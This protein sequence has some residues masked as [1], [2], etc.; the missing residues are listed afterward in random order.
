MPQYFLNQNQQQNGD[1]EVHQERCT[2]MP[3]YPEALG[4][5]ASCHGAVEEA[6][7]RHPSWY[8]IN[9]CAFCSGACHTS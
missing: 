4:Y 9:G 8:R 6:K 1:Y 7:R 2:Y 3:S 5:H